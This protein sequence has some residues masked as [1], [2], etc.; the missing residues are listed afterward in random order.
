MRALPI[1][2]LAVSLLLPTL[3][4]AQ[5]DVMVTLT[6]GDVR[7]KVKGQGKATVVA[8]VENLSGRELNGV[9]IAAYYSAND[10]L[11]GDDATWRVHEF[12][13][14]P[15][16][17]PGNSTTLKFSDTD[18]FEYV[19]LQVRNAQYGRGLSFNGKAV[20]LAGPLSERDGVLYISTRDL[21]NTVGGGISYDAKTYMIVLERRGVS[22]RVQ[23][24]LKYALVGETQAPLAHPVIEVDGHSLLPL[25]DIAALFGL[26]VT[27]DSELNLVELSEQ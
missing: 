26:S 16:L 2:L 20:R 5:G 18:A 13:F 17:L 8:R 21:M 11:P 3:A 14:E 10:A 23:P 24:K 4:L 7:G 25:R 6:G 27:E 12:V 15:P 19:L 22:V 9:R 1:L